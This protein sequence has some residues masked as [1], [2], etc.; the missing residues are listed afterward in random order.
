MESF[1]RPVF[2]NDLQKL[3]TMFQLRN[4]YVN[5]TPYQTMSDKFTNDMSRLQKEINFLQANLIA[6]RVGGIALIILFYSFFLMEEEARDW[7]KNFDIK[8][9]V[10]AYGSLDDSSGEGNIGMDD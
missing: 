1:A 10:K 7:K 9:N 4:Y 8:F 6:K 2:K 5:N 3:L